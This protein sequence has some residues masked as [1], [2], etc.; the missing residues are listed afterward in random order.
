MKKTFQSYAVVW[1]ICFGLFQLISFVAPNDFKGHFWIGWCFI[2]AAFGGQLFCAHLTFKAENHQ[3]LF[4]SIPLTSLSYLGLTA[5]LFF[6]GLTMAIPAIPE[7]IGVILCAVILAFTAI[8]VISAREA[9]QAVE[10][11][12]LRIKEK[13]VLIRMLTADAQTLAAKAQ[14]EPTRILTK[15]VYEALRYSDPM[16]NEAL[17]VYEEQITLKFKEFER[18]VLAKESTAT[19]LSD[20][21]LILIQD[22]NTRCKYL[23]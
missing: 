13:T 1:G 18:A 11:V 15:K 2:S 23:K 6:G 21:L 10:A 9:A 12:D 16:S 7:W 22:R 14:E 3:K 4:Y 8:A 20:E 17:A 19:S 5:M